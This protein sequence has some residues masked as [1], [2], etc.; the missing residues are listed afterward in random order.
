MPH[1]WSNSCCHAECLL[2]W[3]GD[4]ESPAGRRL[5]RLY[6]EALQMWTAV[7]VGYPDRVKVGLCTD[8]PRGA[9]REASARASCADADQRQHHHSG[10]NMPN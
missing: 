6:F 7:Q 1:I 4:P 8:I 9:P 10:D 2:Q 3:R 5:D